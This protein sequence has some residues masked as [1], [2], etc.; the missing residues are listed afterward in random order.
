MQGGTES[1]FTM[2]NSEWWISTLTVH[3]NHLG[4]L[5]KYSSFAPHFIDSDVI[6]LVYS[7]GTGMPS[8]P[9]VYK[10]LASLGNTGRRRVVLGHT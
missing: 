3:L 4:T 5:K 8:I 1:C 6:G 10:L 9:G 7:L 2:Q